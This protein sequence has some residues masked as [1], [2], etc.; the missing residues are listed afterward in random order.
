MSSEYV[1][2]KAEEYGCN[3]SIGE[4][5]DRLEFIMFDP[6]TENILSSVKMS[7]EKMLEALVEGMRVVS[8]WMNSSEFESKLKQAIQEL[9]S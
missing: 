6:K 3:F 8:Y 2:K 7:P 9:L 1:L 5:S 4:M